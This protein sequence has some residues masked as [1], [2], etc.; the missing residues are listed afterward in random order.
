MKHTH[1]NHF[2][3]LTSVHKPTTLT[4]IMS[5]FKFKNYVHYVIKINGSIQISSLKNQFINF[6]MT[7]KKKREKKNI[8]RSNLTFHHNIR[9]IHL[10]FVTIT[11]HWKQKKMENLSCV[12]CAA[13]ARSSFSNGMGNEN[14]IEFVCFMVKIEVVN[15]EN[16]TS[17]ARLDHHHKFIKY[18]RTPARP[19]T[20]SLIAKYSK[21][22]KDCFIY[23][24]I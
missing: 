22:A 7:M 1:L 15:S 2:H 8:W 3:P 19:H 23:D 17:A 4:H 9:K 11:T 10:K 24:Q 13:K 16:E 12:R 6:G 5:F 18:M 21:A 14:S 20:H